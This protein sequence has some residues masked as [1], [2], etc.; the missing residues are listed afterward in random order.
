MVEQ[1]GLGVDVDLCEQSCLNKSDIDPRVVGKTL[2]T[3]TVMSWG[4]KR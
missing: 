2:F 3:H 1:P 4:L